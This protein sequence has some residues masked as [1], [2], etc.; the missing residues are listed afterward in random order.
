[1]GTYEFSYAYLGDFDNQCDVDFQDFAILA[2]AWLTEEGQTGY[3][4]ICDIGQPID[5]RIDMLD[6]EVFVQNWLWGT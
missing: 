2:L 4:S 3:N 5:Q 6:L 1:M